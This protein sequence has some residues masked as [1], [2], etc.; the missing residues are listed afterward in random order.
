M[1]LTVNNLS[2]KKGRNDIVQH[3]TTAFDAGQ[4]SCIIGV[5]GS[6]K[7]MLLKTLLGLEK[8]SG[9]VL[10]DQAPLSFSDLS[11]IPQG[12]EDLHLTVFEVILLGLHAELNW[13][14]SSEQLTQVEHLLSDMRLSHLADRDFSTLSGGQK[15]MILL[16][17]ALIKKP[18]VIIADEPTSAL[19]LANQLHYIETLKHYIKSQQAIGIIV[20]HDLTLTSRYADRLYVMQQGQLTAEGTVTDLMT[21]ERLETL[22]DV[23]LEISRTPAGFI[24]I[25]PIQPKETLL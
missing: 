17:Q 22:Y 21:R 25:I 6:G 18:K 20:L 5:N 2:L 10:L 23:K 13:R 8:G 24:S 3:V 11:Y 1:K 14:V 12:S 7:S 16:A 15:Q 9:T 19:D 4:L